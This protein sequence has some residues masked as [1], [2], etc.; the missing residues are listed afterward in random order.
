MEKNL[1]DLIDDIKRGKQYVLLMRIK[2]K[3]GSI[4]CVSPR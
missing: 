3:R 2:A 1:H 4:L